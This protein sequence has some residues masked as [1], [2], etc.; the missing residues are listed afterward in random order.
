VGSAT[1]Q[2]AFAVNGNSWDI[3]TWQIDDISL[4][5]LIPANATVQNITLNSG[6]SACFD[7]TQTITVAGSG[8]TFIV[9]SGG[10]ASLIA[11]ISI[12]YLPGTWAKVGGYMLGKIAPDGPFCGFKEASIVNADSGEEKPPMV[13][14][15]TNLKV[16]PNPTSGNFRVELS[17]E[18]QIEPVRIEIFGIR[19]DKVL[20]EE[21][22]GEMAHE[23]SLSGYPAGI[24]FIKVVAGE[25][26]LNAKLVKTR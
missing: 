21:I 8:T 24:Y 3:G 10:S 13:A 20:S 11:G 12:N 18:R 16:Y 1:F 4:S 9:E 5:G 25:Q 22:F 6:Q 19:G 14:G 26:L 23:F 15:K 7:A 17:G 2:F